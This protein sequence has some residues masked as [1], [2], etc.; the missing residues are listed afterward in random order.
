MQPCKR[1]LEVCTLFLRCDPVGGEGDDTACLDGLYASPTSRY[2]RIRSA[3]TST[4]R[5]ATLRGAF[6]KVRFGTRL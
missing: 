4:S 5:D 1:T 6:G 2:T 3:L